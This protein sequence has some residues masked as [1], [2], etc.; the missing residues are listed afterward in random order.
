MK[1]EVLLSDSIL[2]AADVLARQLGISR[3]ELFRRAVE[4]YIESHRYKHDHVRETLDMIYS[5]ES[6]EL[7]EALAQMQF[8]SLEHWGRD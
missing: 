1:T 3:S 2:E 8:A 6:S 4:E 5:Q 7:D